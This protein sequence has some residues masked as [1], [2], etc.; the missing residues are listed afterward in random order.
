MNYCDIIISVS[1]VIIG[2]DLNNY[3]VINDPDQICMCVSFMAFLS[4]IK[5]QEG[6]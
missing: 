2:L 6:P 3:I 1:F 5:N 4:H